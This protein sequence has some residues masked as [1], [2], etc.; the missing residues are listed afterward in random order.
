M[1]IKLEDNFYQE[2]M[3]F[4]EGLKKKMKFLVMVP[5]PHMSLM[6]ADSLEFKMVWPNIM[7][8]RSFKSPIITLL[9]DEFKKSADLYLKELDE[10]IKEIKK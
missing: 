5:K 7:K 10:I 8:K 3:K 6:L 1:F 2:T 4:L 9:R